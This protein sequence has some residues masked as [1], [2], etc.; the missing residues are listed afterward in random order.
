M[1]RARTATALVVAAVLVVGG[2][3]ALGAAGLVSLPGPWES[4]GHVAGEPVPVPGPDE[5]EPP[6][7]LRLPGPRP[8]APVLAPARGPRADPSAVRARLASF[9]RDRDLGQHVGVVVRDLVRDRP[10]LALGGSDPFLPASTLKLFTATAVLA[11]LGPDNRFRT[12]VVLDRVGVGPPTAVLVG[13]GDPLLAAAPPGPGES[14]VPAT[15]SVSGLAADAART[16]RADGVRRLRVGFDADLFVGPAKSPA[17]P[18]DYVRDD[19]VSP[20]SA[21]WVDE[22]RVGPDLA[23]RSPDPA[24]AA[25]EAFADALRTRGVRVVGTPV[26]ADA[27]ASAAVVAEAEGAPLS[28]V[29]EHVLQVSDNEGAE[30]LLR[31]VALAT[32]R[33]A[34]FAGGSQAVR[35]VLTGLGIPM[36]G[37]RA[38]DGSGLS[39]HDRV[40]REALAQ[41]LQ[42]GADPALPELRTVT[43]GL[44]VAG[45]SGSL[46]YRFLDA[47]A[48]DAR[49]LVRAKT[50]T[51]SGV[52]GLAGTTVTLDGTLLGFGLLTDRVP[53]SD[54]LDAR[55]LLDDMAAALAGC[56]CAR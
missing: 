55:G 38:Y 31:H 25:A 8:A 19:V 23:E 9:L 11:E 37:V 21:L 24:V 28:A 40:T 43:A 33:P 39:R 35:E 5:V 50:G 54:T 32:A 30:V 49:G 16:L 12:E 34:S 41:V 46:A 29:V 2:A 27:P 45:F 14:D 26:Q 22:G 48:A 3:V 20:V 4:A 56:G 7:S 47:E 53:L 18:P 6:P 10:V 13:G 51:L 44:P 42:L 36:T 15:V 17:W 52:H 1:G